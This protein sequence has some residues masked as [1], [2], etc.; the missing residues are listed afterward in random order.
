MGKGNEAMATLCGNKMT[1]S[2]ADRKAGASFM[3]AIMLGVLC[4]HTPF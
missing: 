1:A 4:P 2:A 3:L